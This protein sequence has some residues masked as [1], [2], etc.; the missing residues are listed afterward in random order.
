MNGL[1]IAKIIANKRRERGL[2]QEE[3]AA[4]LG[5]SKAAV[6]KWENGQSYPD[7]TFLPQLASFF[8]VSVDELIGYEPQMIKEDIK[9]EY[10]RLSMGFAERPFEQVYQECKELVHKYYSCFPLLLQIATL[11]LNH[12]MLAG[13]KELQNSMLHGV[14]E[15]CTRIKN[16]SHDALLAKDAVIVEALAYLALQSPEKVLNLLGETFRPQTAETELIS[17]AYQMQ[18]NAAKAL[19]A[20]QIGAYQ[21]LLMLVHSSVQLMMLNAADPD[22]LDEILKRTTGIIKLYHIDELHPN[23][24]LGVY[25]TAAHIFCNNNEKERALEMLGNYV[26]TVKGFKEYVL[27][28]DSYFDRIEGWISEFALGKMAPR[29]A[30][31]IKKSI[32]QGVVD[33]PAFE[34]LKEDAEYRRLIK[35]LNLYMKE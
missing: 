33:N 3:L 12:F 30:E 11:Y 5:V 23:T 17:R 22:R 26:R 31:I 25:L 34:V 15:L 35:E 20:V 19:E 1:N 27:H 16:E 28:G 2:T 7:I 8:N 29:N 21:Y 4:Y 32:L 9:K 24:T 13:Q 14:I 6:S 10:Q 18:G